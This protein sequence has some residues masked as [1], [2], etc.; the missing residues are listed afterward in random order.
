MQGKIVSL[1]KGKEVKAIPLEMVDITKLL[2]N[3]LA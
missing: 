1:V 3:S 2:Y